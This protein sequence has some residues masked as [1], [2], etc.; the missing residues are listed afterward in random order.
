MDRDD[1]IAVSLPPA[2]PPA[3]AKREATIEA[4]LRQFD[5]ETPRAPP[6]PN[7]DGL[8]APSSGHSSPR[9]LSR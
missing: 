5:G 7:A 9:R 4:A 8:P 2:P 3:P 1:D 6:G